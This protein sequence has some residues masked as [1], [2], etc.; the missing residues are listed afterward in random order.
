M[1][2][3]CIPP[4][5]LL[6]S[7]PPWKYQHASKM[8]ARYLHKKERFEVCHC[9]IQID[10]EYTMS[11]GETSKTTHFNLLVWNNEMKNNPQCIKCQE[12]IITAAINKQADHLWI[13]N[14][15]QIKLTHSS[16]DP[17]KRKNERKTNFSPGFLK[18]LEVLQKRVKQ[19][20]FH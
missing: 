3:T 13:I 12:N 9:L 16:H 2:L 15:W 5:P 10:R 4:L 20:F 14:S 11:L 6:S 17:H 8:K 18:Y 1:I 7:S 19:R